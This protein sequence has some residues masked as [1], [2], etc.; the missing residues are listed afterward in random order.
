M[1]HTA[2]NR[3]DKGRRHHIPVCLLRA[4]VQRPVHQDTQG[5]RQQ[6]SLAA[7]P[8]AAAFVGTLEHCGAGGTGPSERAGLYPGRDL[9][10][11]RPFPSAP[12][13]A[14]CFKEGKARRVWNHL[15]RAGGE[16]TRTTGRALP[17]H[18]GEEHRYTGWPGSRAPRA[19]ATQGPAPPS[20]RCVPR[21]CPW[22]RPSCDCFIHTVSRAAVLK[23]RI[24]KTAYYSL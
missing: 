24:L 18:I 14:V 9:D 8:A 12:N 23:I 20:G 3:K 22:H 2:G 19:Q 6:V 13:E 1:A 15:S 21:E 11:L 4:G 16:Q 5:A 10:Q 17:E 7:T